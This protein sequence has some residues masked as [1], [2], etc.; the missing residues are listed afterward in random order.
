M[1]TVTGTALIQ[2][3]FALLNVFLPGEA[4]P[5]ADGAYALQALNDLLDEW[6]NRALMI[7]MIAREPFDLV[8]GQG[9][10]DNPYTIGDGG[11]FDTERPANQ[12]SIVSANLILTATSP[13]ERVTLGIYTDQG[14]NANQL[15]DMSSGQ[16]TGLYYNPTFTDNL[17]SIFLWPVPDVATNDLELFLQK[18][19]G[20]FADL[21]TEYEVPPGWP[22]ALKYNLA[23][24]LQ[25][26]YGKTLPDSALRIAV[27]SLGTVKR[28][29]TRM[30][31]LANDA[32]FIGRRSRPYNIDTGP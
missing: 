27:S 30:T 17:G 23:D 12:N 20:Q 2:D 6:S 8:D 5:A 22:R 21:S 31:E 26:P 13:E 3:S 14:Y 29:N 7:P 10:P 11:D 19:V 4:L 18:A 28:A 9:G 16:P 25:A 1:P 24:A 32:W 15:P